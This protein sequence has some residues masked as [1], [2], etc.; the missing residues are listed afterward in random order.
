M[1]W[2]GFKLSVGDDGCFRGLQQMLLV[3]PYMP[4][5]CRE[6]SSV[7][8]SATTPTPSTI[9][10]TAEVAAWLLTRRWRASESRYVLAGAVVALTRGAQ[11]SRGGAGHEKEVQGGV[12]QDSMEVVGSEH[13]GLD[14]LF[15]ILVGH[16][17]YAYKRLELTLS[18]MAA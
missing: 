11:N 6:S 10:R 12:D 2:G 4:L 16:F 15:P 13:L 7:S 9:D 3:N 8:F 18:T 1:V 17:Y 5:R 14:G